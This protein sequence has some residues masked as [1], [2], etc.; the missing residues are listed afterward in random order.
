MNLIPEFIGKVLEGYLTCSPSEN[1]YNAFPAI[2]ANFINKVE[3]RGR[4]WR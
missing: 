1:G 4:P 3:H 2:E